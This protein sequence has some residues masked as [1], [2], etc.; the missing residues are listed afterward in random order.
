VSAHTYF[1]HINANDKWNSKFIFRGVK[2]AAT[3][4]GHIEPPL[5]AE[6]SFVNQFEKPISL[7]G[8]RGPDGRWTVQGWHIKFDFRSPYSFLGRWQRTP[9]PAP[10][11]W[12]AD[13]VRFSV[14]P[15]ESVLLIVPLAKI[16]SVA[17]DLSR[18]DVRLYLSLEP[19]DPNLSS[20]P[21]TLPSKV[22]GRCPC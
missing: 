15:G 4:G 1:D 3:S 5:F 11:S 8:V 16:Q 20:A 17:A 10:G 22:L 9:G 19:F 2:G 18:Y 13:D 14:G 12:L 7:Y 6:F 21:F